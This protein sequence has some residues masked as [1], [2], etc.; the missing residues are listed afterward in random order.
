MMY[1]SVVVVF[2]LFV[3]NLCAASD[4]SGFW[5][6][7]RDPVWIDVDEV[8]GTGLAVRN[9][10]DPSSVGFAVLREVVGGAKQGQWTGEV[11]VPQLG[12]YKP[13]VMTL[14]NVKTLKMN[15]KIG[16]ITR[17]LEWTKVS[18]VPQP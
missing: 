12:D 7:P 5:Q 4:V 18:L 6:H 9:D 13:V 1:R 8:L 16:F 17:T 14:P 11:Y 10:N 2:L 15:V 3:C